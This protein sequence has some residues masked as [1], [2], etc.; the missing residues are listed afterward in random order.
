MQV[1]SSPGDPWDLKREL[2][3]NYLD[4][5]LPLFPGHLQ[6]VITR[7]PSGLADVICRTLLH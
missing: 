2:S 3:E 4:I 1:F 5:F 7:G 6:A